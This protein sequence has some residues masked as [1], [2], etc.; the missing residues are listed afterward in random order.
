[1]GRLGLKSVGMEFAKMSSLGKRRACCHFHSLHGETQTF[2]FGE[3][4]FANRDMPE[5]WLEDIRC[6]SQCDAEATFKN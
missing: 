6:M 1:M 4:L 5:S 2:Q 3:R